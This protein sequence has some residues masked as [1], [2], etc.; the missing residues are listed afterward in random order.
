MIFET[1]T[2]RMTLKR[3]DSHDSFPERHMANLHAVKHQKD[4]EFTQSSTTS[5]PPKS[6]N[7]SPDGYEMRGRYHEAAAILKLDLEESKTPPSV[8]SYI[9]DPVRLP[10]PGIPKTPSI[11]RLGSLPIQRAWRR[12]CSREPDLRQTRVIKAMMLYERGELVGTNQECHRCQEGGGASRECVILPS[13]FSDTCSNCLYDGVDEQCSIASDASTTTTRGNTT[14]IE[15]TQPR[16]SDFM[17]V[18]N[19]I[20]QMK[21]SDA[22]GSDACTKAQIIEEAALQVA[23]A[24]REWGHREGQ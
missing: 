17:V 19:L 9:Y 8:W 1:Y 2:A 5:R 6:P 10:P 21:Q 18:L 22:K 20:E 3:I 11:R 7:E 4:E 23:R 14:K 15:G 12:R 13:M 16:K 24:A